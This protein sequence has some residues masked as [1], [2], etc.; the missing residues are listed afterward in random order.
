MVEEAPPAAA[1]VEEA[2]TEVVLEAASEALES[3]QES[4]LP[5]EMVTGDV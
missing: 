5:A 4:P 2:E 1:P 3:R